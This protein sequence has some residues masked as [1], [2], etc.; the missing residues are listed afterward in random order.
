MLYLRKPYLYT[1]KF[2]VLKQIL[3]QEI[4][5]QNLNRF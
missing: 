4:K 5:F 2:D 3:F 1:R